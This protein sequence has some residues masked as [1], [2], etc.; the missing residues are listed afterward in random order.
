[1]NKEEIKYLIEQVVEQEVIN[2]GKAA[3]FKEQIMQMVQQAVAASEDNVAN[4]NDFIQVI[5]SEIDKIKADMDL[6]YDMIARTLKS[7][8]YEVFYKSTK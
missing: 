1:M 6:T 8:P 3:L 4:Q 2:I 5:D 7:I